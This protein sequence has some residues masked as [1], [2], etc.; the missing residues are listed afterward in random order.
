MFIVTGSLGNHFGYLFELLLGLIK[1]SFESSAFCRYFGWEN[2]YRRRGGMELTVKVT[3][4][5]MTPQGM[6]PPR[7]DAIRA[8]SELG[9]DFPLGLRLGVYDTYLLGSPVIPVVLFEEGI[10]LV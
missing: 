4:Q 5:R 9:S 3:P 1:L 10:H 8:T 7:I 6:A 2:K